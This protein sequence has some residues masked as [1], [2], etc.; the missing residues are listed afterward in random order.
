VGASSKRYQVYSNRV[1]RLGPVRVS[2]NWLFLKYLPGWKACGP[3]REMEAAEWHEV[4]GILRQTGSR[5]TVA[6]TA[7]WA[8]R[9][10][11]VTPFPRKFPEQARALKDGAA[12]GLIEIANHGLT[13]CVL[14]GNAFHPRWFSGN[15]TFH[16]E[17]WD[18]VPPAVQELHIR[19]SQEILQDYFG[20]PVLTFVPPGNVYTEETLA[21]AE[22]YGLRYVSCNTPPRRA[23]RLLVLGNEDV[24]AFHDRDL[25]LHGVSWLRASI[26]RHQ[27]RRCCSIAELAAAKGAA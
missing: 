14:E 3:Y 1:W 27:G 23:G 5:M 18:W 6:I 10:D 25:V 4:F 19:R 2:G 11:R 26:D 13:H 22:R 15:R 7:A 24:D 8:D 21:I 9:S 16:R 20:S 17:F 12:E